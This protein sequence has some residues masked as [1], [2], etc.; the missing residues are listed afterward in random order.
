MAS[1]ASGLWYPD[2]ITPMSIIQMIKA[3][4]ESVGPRSVYSAASA[5]ARA[6][7]ITALAGQT[8]PVVPTT[9]APVFVFQTDTQVLWMHTGSTTAQRVTSTRVYGRV[10]RAAGL[11]TTATG[12]NVQIPWTELDGNSTHPSMWAS[13]SPT[14][15]VI[16]AD[17][18]YQING[19]AGFAVATA[20]WR[21]I[22]IKLNGSSYLAEDSRMGITGGQIMLTVST[23]AWL[24]AGN[25]LE[26][27]TWQ[28]SGG[29]LDLAVDAA[30]M[31]LT[32]SAA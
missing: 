14:R 6:A 30:P 17:G 23:G 18:F 16:P 20:G 27:Q 28:N 12:A 32:V 19:S 31:F 22:V 13:G 5:S 8:P 25:Y 7:Y 15:L 26:L 10:T 21:V 9:A 24:A 1:T 11:S 2:G 29:N 3:A 4:Q